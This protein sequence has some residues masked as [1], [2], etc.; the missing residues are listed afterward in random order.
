VLNHLQTIPCS[1]QGKKSPVGVVQG[2]DID[3][4][5]AHIAIKRQAKGGFKLSSSNAKAG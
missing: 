5:V 2:C 4:H 1:G 3:A